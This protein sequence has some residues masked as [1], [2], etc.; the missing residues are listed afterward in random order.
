M[1]FFFRRGWGWLACC[2]AGNRNPGNDVGRQRMTVP[3]RPD[4]RKWDLVE[5]TK[6]CCATMIRPSR[7]SSCPAD[8]K[9]L[10][11]YVVVAAIVIIVI[12]QIIL[13]SVLLCDKAEA[14]ASFSIFRTLLPPPP[15]TPF[16]TE[17]DSQ[18]QRSARSQLV[19]ITISLI[20]WTHFPSKIG[21]FAKLFFYW[22][23]YCCT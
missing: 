10:P 12:S 8:L 17:M 19:V 3:D 14:V 16:T 2:A 22:F 7:L 15:S 9:P 5:E 6:L 18:R 11:L 1:K 23:P 20:I 13:G 21:I 4:V